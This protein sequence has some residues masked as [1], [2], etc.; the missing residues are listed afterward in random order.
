MKRHYDQG[1]SYK[2]NHLIRVGLQFYS[3][4]SLAHYDHSRK[5]DSMKADMVLEKE[6][7]VLHLDLKTTRRDWH[8]QAA[9]RKLF[10]TMHRA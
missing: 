4:K 9:R 1:N 7:R 8:S 6:L 10:S 5:H 3:F 2:G